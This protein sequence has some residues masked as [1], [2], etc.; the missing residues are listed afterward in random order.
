MDELGAAKEK[1]E[2]RRVAGKQVAA[3]SSRKK[4][5]GMKKG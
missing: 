2:G 3:V 4:G 1:K 5:E